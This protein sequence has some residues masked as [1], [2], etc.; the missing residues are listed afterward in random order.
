MHVT[1]KELKEA[2]RSLDLT[3]ER[4][5]SIDTLAEHL[6][7]TEDDNEVYSFLDEGLPLLTQSERAA[8]IARL[9][10][11]IRQRANRL[12]I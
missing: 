3:Q 8:L 4:L 7:F 10:A 11:N 9:I 2:L 1:D 5:N 12:D 6:L